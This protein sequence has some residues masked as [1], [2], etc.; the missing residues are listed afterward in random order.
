MRLHIT[1]QLEG[2]FGAAA[3]IAGKRGGKVSPA[4]AVC[5]R[6]ADIEVAQPGTTTMAA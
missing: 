4:L 1:S 3:K 6:A 5:G 2:Q